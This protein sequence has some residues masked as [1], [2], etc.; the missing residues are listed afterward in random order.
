M[1]L[2]KTTYLALN[3]VLASWAASNYLFNFELGKFNCVMTS[4]GQ[5]I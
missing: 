5:D 3:S 1:E 2:Q 4:H